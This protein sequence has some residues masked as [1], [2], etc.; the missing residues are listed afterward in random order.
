MATGNLWQLK[1][2]TGAAAEGG[3]EGGVPPLLEFL[4]FGPFLFYLFF[5][6]WRASFCDVFIIFFKLFFTSYFSRYIKATI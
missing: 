4:S 3:R 6:T 1:L 2:A 5:A